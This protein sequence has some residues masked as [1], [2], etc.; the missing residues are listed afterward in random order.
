MSGTQVGSLLHVGAGEAALVP[1]ESVC[2]VPAA[3]VEATSELVSGCELLLVVGSALRAW[4]LVGRAGTHGCLP[5]DSDHLP[6]TA[7]AL[8]APGTC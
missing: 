8:C 5:R 7:P 2:G 1:A 4:W 6:T 3:K